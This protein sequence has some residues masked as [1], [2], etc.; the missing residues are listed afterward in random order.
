MK[1]ARPDFWIQYVMKDGEE[2][3]TTSRNMTHAEVMVVAA[4]IDRVKATISD[5]DKWHCPKCN[6]PH[7]A[8]N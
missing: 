4:A 1:S 6:Q 2:E 3:L 7:E 8:E 5:G